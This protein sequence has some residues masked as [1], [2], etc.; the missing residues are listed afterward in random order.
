MLRLHSPPVSPERTLEEVVEALRA[1][2]IDYMLTGSIA[3][4]FHGIP[5]STQ[6]IDLVVAGTEDQLLRFARTLM[7]RGYYVSEDA[8]REA[9]EGGSQFNVIDRDTAWK[10]DLILRKDREFSRTEFARRTRADALG[11]SLWVAT[12]EDVVLA[13]L[14]WA[15]ITGSERQL[16]DVAGILTSQGDAL[17]TG[18]VERWVDELGVDEQWGRAKEY[19]TERE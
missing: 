3:A 8:V 9:F 15:R 17:D 12:A 14:E 19:L 10:V 13:K 1:A 4:S 2:G 18:Y 7:D 16:E 5:R 6:D 11:L